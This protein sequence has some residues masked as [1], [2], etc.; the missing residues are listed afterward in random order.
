MSLNSVQQ[1]EFEPA[2]QRRVSGSAKETKVLPKRLQN[3]SSWESLPDC[4]DRLELTV[5][6]QSGRLIYEVRNLES[7]PTWVDK[8]AQD[9][10]EIHR[11]AFAKSREHGTHAPTSAA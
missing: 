6:G 4:Q 5:L 2:L 1:R 8:Q 3:T 9:A 10:S 7:S 11:F